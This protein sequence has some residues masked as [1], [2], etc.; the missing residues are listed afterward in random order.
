M[1]LAEII[2]RVF[3]NKLAWVIGDYMSNG[4]KICALKVIRD[5]SGAPL[6]TAKWILDNYDTLKEFSQINKDETVEMPE[7]RGITIA[8]KG[9][10]VQS[11]YAT[12]NLL[13]FSVDIADLDEDIGLAELMLE[14]ARETQVAIY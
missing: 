9:G 10:L 3:E 7:Y 6:K 8:V 14:K 5:L 1:K 12:K 11:V 13:D 4:K 2:D